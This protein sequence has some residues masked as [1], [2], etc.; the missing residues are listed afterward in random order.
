MPDNNL[1]QQFLLLQ[2]KIY[3]L[4]LCV[5]FFDPSHYNFTMCFVFHSLQESRW[6][7][8]RECTKS[9]T[10]SGDMNTWWRQHITKVHTLQIQHQHIRMYYIENNCIFE[11][12]TTNGTCLHFHRKFVYISSHKIWLPNITVVLILFFSHSSSYFL[13]LPKCLRCNIFSDNPFAV[14]WYRWESERERIEKRDSENT[15]LWNFKD[16]K[17]FD[18]HINKMNTFTTKMPRHNAFFPFYRLIFLCIASC[19]VSQT[20]R[21]LFAQ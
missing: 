17:K 13:A 11:A 19:L 7:N 8:E 4:F 20:K 1:S 2:F 21:T 15:S 5:L 9:L 10:K 16:L 3:T 14:L 6:A 18:D 12:D